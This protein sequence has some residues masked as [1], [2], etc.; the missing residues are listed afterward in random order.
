MSQILNNLV[1]YQI[2][3]SVSTFEHLDHLLTPHILQYYFHEFLFSLSNF[4]INYYYCFIH[5]I[6]LKILWPFPLHCI[7]SCI[8]K[9]TFKISAS[10][11]EDTLYC[12]PPCVSAAAESFQFIFVWKRLHPDVIFSTDISTNSRIELVVTCFHCFEDAFPFIVF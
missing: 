8:S 9:P 12:L 3:V 2:P 1:L 7:P 6:C 4:S 5:S 11:P 10:L